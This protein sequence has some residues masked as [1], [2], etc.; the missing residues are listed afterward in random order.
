MKCEGLQ[1]IV[2]TFKIIITISDTT[3]TKLTDT[4]ALCDCICMW[5]RQIKREREKK[6]DKIDDKD[7][8]IVSGKIE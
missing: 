3:P 8:I 1:E 4:H 6:H 2:L 5:S 7:F